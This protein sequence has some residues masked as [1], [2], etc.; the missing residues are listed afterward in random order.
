MATTIE[1]GDIRR[2]DM[3]WYDFPVYGDPKYAH[4]LRG[5][6]RVLVVQNNAA[7]G[8]S[9]HDKV[10]VCPVST[11]REKH[12][13]PA[14]GPRR[15]FQALLGPSDCVGDEPLD[16]DSIVHLEEMYTLS[17]ADCRQRLC[18]ITPEA[19]KRVNRA[20]VVSLDLANGVTAEALDRLY[21]AQKAL[22]EVV[23]RF[24]EAWQPIR[25]TIRQLP[26]S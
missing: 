26:D 22:E 16:H 17:K 2:G 15:A 23:D 6:H 14:G 8:R 24:V 11:A 12:L 10:I 3:F 9:A 7:N 1:P 4:L 25:D 18:A 19:L 13:D 21:E 20:L 5:P